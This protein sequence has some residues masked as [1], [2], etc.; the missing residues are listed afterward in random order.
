MHGLGH[1]IGLEVHDPDQYYRTGV[2]AAGSAFTIEPGIY[3]REHVL[4]E[5]PDSPRNRALATKLRGAVQTYRNIGV[6][7]EDDYLATEKGVEWISRA[8]REIEEVEAAM[9]GSYAGPPKRDPAL[10]EKYKGE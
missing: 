8:P 2:I 4:E 9:R 1:G 5:M 7:I 10:V 3:V 6:R